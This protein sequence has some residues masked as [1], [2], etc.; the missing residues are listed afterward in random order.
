MTEGAVLVLPEY[1]RPKR[2][3]DIT[4]FI[5][6]RPLVVYR[7]HS[8]EFRGPAKTRALRLIHYFQRRKRI[9]GCALCLICVFMNAVDDCT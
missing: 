8:N 4:G 6:L 5:S 7:A 2:S 9:W 1:D 3:S